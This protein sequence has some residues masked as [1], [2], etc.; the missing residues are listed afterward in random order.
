MSRPSLSLTVL[1]TVVLLVATGCPTEN[2][3]VVCDVPHTDTGSDAVAAN[4]SAANDT[5]GADS[6]RER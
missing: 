4:D 6:R 5:S 2:V 3:I 1:C